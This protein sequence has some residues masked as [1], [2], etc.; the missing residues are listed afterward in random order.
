[1]TAGNVDDRKPVY[2][3]C[4]QVQELTGDNVLTIFADQGYTGEDVQDDAND[5][6]IKLVVMKKPEATLPVRC[7]LGSR[8]NQGVCAV[9]DSLGCGEI[10]WLDDSFSSVST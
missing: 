7:I 8:S 6:I 3:L 2:D 5:N 4:E 9:T 1:M 10:V